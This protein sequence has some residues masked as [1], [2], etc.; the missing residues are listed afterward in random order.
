MQAHLQGHGCADQPPSAQHQDQ[1]L[2]AMQADHQRLVRQQRLVYQSLQNSTQHHLLHAKI[3]LPAGQVLEVS[4]AWPGMYTACMLGRPG[5]GRLLGAP[6]S[7]S[8]SRPSRPTTAPRCSTP[9]RV[10][11]TLVS[12]FGR[13]AIWSTTGSSSSASPSCALMTW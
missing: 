9:R 7:F 8:T 5:A 2:G 3:Q 4:M 1:M 11:S 13:L 12:S 6:N 10:V